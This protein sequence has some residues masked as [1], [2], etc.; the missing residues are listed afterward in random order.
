VDV[1]VHAFCLTKLNKMYKLNN[2]RTLVNL[3]K[4]TYIHIGVSPPSKGTY[5]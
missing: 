2:M 5:S 3:K 4:Y 1:D